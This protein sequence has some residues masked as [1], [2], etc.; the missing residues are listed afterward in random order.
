[1]TLVLNFLI[2]GI[3]YLEGK[4][5][6]GKGLLSGQLKPVRLLMIGSIVTIVGAAGLFFATT[7]LEKRV[8][9]QSPYVLLFKTHRA[10]FSGDAYSLTR[11]DRS[12]QYLLF[13]IS[14]L[15]TPIPTLMYYV[16]LPDDRMPGPF[17]GEY[18]FPTIA[19]WARRL[20][21][22]ADPYSWETAR[23]ELFAP[24]A[25][26]NFGSNVWSTLMRDLIA[27]F[28]K[29]GNGLFLLVLGFFG[30]LIYEKQKVSPSVRN[31]AVLVY[32]R[33]VFAFSG[34][35]SLLFMAIFS[36]QFY[37]AIFLAL[38]GNREFVKISPRV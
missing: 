19:R 25:A 30:Q 32:L 8:Q 22:T 17:Y 10:Q 6:I 31:A 15:S 37:F 36:W 29:V 35:I 18:N 23:A 20:T 9:Q 11:E 12:L 21:F 38:R 24:L 26:I 14:Y 34:L 4:W 33:M 3:A 7:Y 27:D 5:S 13:S 2:L 28:G 1:M 16:D